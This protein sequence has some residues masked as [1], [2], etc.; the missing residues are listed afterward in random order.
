MCKEFRPLKTNGTIVES[1]SRSTCEPRS[2]LQKN[3]KDTNELQ[4]LIEKYQRTLKID[5]HDV[6]KKYN[7]NV[8]NSDCIFFGK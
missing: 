3:E 8:L 6:N 7:H 1:L 2:D 4:K 5:G